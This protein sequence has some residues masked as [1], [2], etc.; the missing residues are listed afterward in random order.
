MC[1]IA[2]LIAGVGSDLGAL[3]RQMT[4]LASHRGP[5]SEGY[6]LFSRDGRSLVAAA[7]ADTPAAAFTSG[8][9]H[10]PQTTIEAAC[11]FSIGV[12]LG[13]RRL[14]V[15]DLSPAAHQ[16]MCTEDQRYWIVYNGEVYN[17]IELREQL[18]RLGCVFH[19]HSDTEVVLQAYRTWG[20]ACLE[21][22]NGMFALVIFDRKA[23]RVFCAR[24][25]F[26][27]KPLYYWRSPEGMVAFASEIKQFSVLPGWRAILNGQRAYDFL[28]WGLFDHSGETL[29]QGVGQ[30]RG[31][32]YLDCGVEEAANAIRPGRWYR[33][34]PRESNADLAQ[35]AGEFRDLLTDSVRLRLRADVAVGSCLSG[36]LDSSF[37]VCIANRLLREHNAHARQKTFSARAEAA[38]Y[39]ESAYA[40]EVIRA[41]QVEGHFTLPSLEQ[42][43]PSL[44]RITWHQD[45]PFGSTSIYAQWK[46]FELAASH[47]VRVMLDGQGADEM[48]AGYQGFFGVRFAALLRSLH[49]LELLRDVRA[50]RRLHGFPVARA[51]RYALNHLLPEALRQPLRALVGKESTRNAAWLN[52]GALGARQVDPTIAVGAKGVGLRD[53]SAAQLLHTSLP[54]LLHWEDRDS[55]AHSVESRVP[56]LD[57]R[58]VEFVLGLP[59]EF[60]LARGVTKVVMREAMTGLVPERIRSRHDKI[61]FATPEEVWMRERGQQMFRQAITTAVEQ[62]RGVLRPG[63]V[64]AV[65]DTIAGRRPFGFHTWRMISFGVWMDRFAVAP[66]G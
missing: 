25:R 58:L 20:R 6:A 35:A 41:T 40:E 52:A 30:L 39:D 17:H 33:L 36:G 24:D 23:R 9:A 50:T 47:G 42:L 19:S 64:D 51:A 60:K 22:F 1:G 8:L 7:G 57:Y 26:G 54:M 53:Y 5:D 3:I 10:A 46:V 37:I 29:F 62:S 12:A 18:Q 15:V 32:E 59:D 4:Q 66:P 56:F 55:M 34:T 11:N 21:R 48:L 43:F 63:A 45:E 13:H 31:G 61:G 44:A 65:E 16:P 2:A 14:A 28:N 49:W 27:V 38:R